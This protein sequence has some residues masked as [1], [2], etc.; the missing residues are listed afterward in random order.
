MVFNEASKIWK[1]FEKDGSEKDFKFS[2]EVHKALLNFF[3]VGEYY[4][5]V[6]NVPQSSFELV[7]PEITNVLGYAKE[8]VDVPFLLNKIHLDDQ[9]YFLTF[10]SKAVEFF[11]TLSLSQIPNYK[12]RYDYRIQNK[13]GN[14]VR[15]L[16]QV[17]TIQH[18]EDKR[19][20]RTFG[21][22][23]DISHLKK[24]GKP[25]LSFIGLNGEPSYID[26]KVDQLFSSDTIALTKRERQVLLLLMEGK[27]SDDISKLL[28]ISK[29][30][31]D[32]HRKNLLTKTN[33][34]NTPSLI[35]YAI[36]KGW[37]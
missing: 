13:D 23:T 20:I 37:V 22:H 18:D 6:F 19:L 21:V 25:V 35:S 26:V 36:K 9:P 31:V 16:Q 29:Q 7:S 10:E 4:Y 14:Y 2:L 12:V 32:T 34:N 28:F 3:Q 27:K 30:T 1:Q 11:S 24:E 8:Q 5:Y 15:V 17:V 33:S